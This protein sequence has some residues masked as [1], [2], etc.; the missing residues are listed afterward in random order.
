MSSPSG[1]SSSGPRSSSW[2][3]S[4]TLPCM[5]NRP[6]AL[7]MSDPT[8]KGPVLGVHQAAG[9]PKEQLIGVAERSA[10]DVPARQA[11]SHSDS[12]GRRY[13]RPGE[14]VRGDPHP[15]RI[16]AVG[17]R[18]VAPLFAGKA[19]PLAEPVAIG[20]GVVPG[21]FG[22]GQVGVRIG[23]IW[24]IDRGG[25]AVCPGRGGTGRRSPPSWRC[26]RGGPGR[27]ADPRCSSATV[28]RPVSPSGIR[29]RPARTTIVVPIAVEV[30]P[31]RSPRRVRSP[32]RRRPRRAWSARPQV[33]SSHPA[34][35]C[36]DGSGSSR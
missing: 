11:Y 12:M 23:R 8:G 27:S 33:R 24:R 18:L 19:F 7:G 31:P 2:H 20:H 17:I 36:I 29:P 22:L 4:N 10:R 13:P 21:D 6:N 14:E 16:L 3:H 5:S 15:L 26:R 32:A 35:A 9:V 1:L 28:R 34:A 25:R 30:P